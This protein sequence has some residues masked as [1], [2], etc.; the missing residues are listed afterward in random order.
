MEHKW[1]ESYHKSFIPV[2]LPILC[3][4]A[5]VNNLVIIFVATSSYRFKQATY[6]SMRFLIVCLAIF[7]ILIVIFSR[8]PIVTGKYP[9]IFTVINNAMLLE[10][11][12]NNSKHQ[13]VVLVTK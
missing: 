8:G 2:I 4:I 6:I 12:I 3:C 9:D 11:L 1:N 5:F 10:F 7:D 13:I